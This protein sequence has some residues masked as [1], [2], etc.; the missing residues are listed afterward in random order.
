MSYTLTISGHKVTE[1][2]EDSTAFEEDAA[3][4]AKQ[5]V[6][7]LEGVTAAYFQGGTIGNVNLQEQ[8]Q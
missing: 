8:G 3:A 4:K 5:F 2:A 6:Q 1:S 7:S